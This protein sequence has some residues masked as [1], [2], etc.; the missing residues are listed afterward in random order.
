MKSKAIP[1]IWRLASQR[2][3]DSW[4]TILWKT[5]TSCVFGF[6]LMFYGQVTL[7]REPD[8]IKHQS[9]S[10]VWYNGAHSG[11]QARLEVRLI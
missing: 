1:N 10:S 6:A 8:L 11:C 2:L 7:K 3:E 5:P 9:S 4:M